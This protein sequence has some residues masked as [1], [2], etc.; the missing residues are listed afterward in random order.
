[1]STRTRIDAWLQAAAAEG[2]LPAE[3]TVADPDTRPWPVVL[4]TAL[5]AWLAALPLI[6]VVGMLLGEALSRG[7]GP[8][9]VGALVLS[10]AAIVLHAKGLPLFAE[11]LAVPALLVGGGSLGFGLYRDLP[12][13]GASAVL[14]AVAL[15]VA[16]VVA[17]AWLRLLLGAA[18]AVL[19]AV[20]WLPGELRLVGDAEMAGFWWSWHAVAA[21]TL[22][23]FAAQARIFASGPAARVGGVLESV[24]AGSFVAIVAALAAWSGMTFLVGASFGDGPGNWAS[25]GAS[26]YAMRW[27]Q[28][29]SAGLAGLGAGWLA[30]RWPALRQ[31]WCGG[32]ALV[33]V[34]LAWFMPALG[35]VLL[36]LAVAA[37]G[38]RW[39]LASAAG[40]SAAWIVGAFYY[41]LDWPLATKAI[42]LVAAGAL[43]GLFA[44]LALRGGPAGHAP[45]SGAGGAIAQP[46]R[47][48]VGIAATLAAVLAVANLGIWQKERLIASG[49]PVF[50]ELAPVDPRSLMQGDYMALAFRLPADVETR[51]EGLASAQRPSVVARRDA[52]GVAT[53]LRADDGQPL[54]D[55][56]LRIELTPKDSR[57]VLVTDAWFFKEGEAERWARARYGEFRVDGSGKALLV[58]LRGDKLQAL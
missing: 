8:Y 23:A 37:T 31:P 24:L 12:E 55:G 2:L 52:Q 57:W 21:L 49:Q 38:Q 9:V 20:A 15:G 47:A 26:A 19:L 45:A 36:L 39:R 5:G 33:L 25:Q 16:A 17:R 6:A 14:A 56:E 44:W 27:L 30:H 11:Q 42:V 34:A 53:L 51:V 4:L 50:V 13:Q 48:T 32:V 41:R 40:V 29:I 3:A 43:L 22:G 1:M 28:G 46:R 10:G 54:A 7:A 18:A 58:G 35:A